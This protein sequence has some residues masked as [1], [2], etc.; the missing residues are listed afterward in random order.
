MGVVL[1]ESQIKQIL[2]EAQGVLSEYVTQNGEM[3]FDLSAH[4]V[5]AS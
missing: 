3:A 5:V 4:I 2:S 1:T